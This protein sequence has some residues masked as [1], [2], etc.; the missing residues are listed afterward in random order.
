MGVNLGPL[1]PS[2]YHSLL[3]QPNLGYSI[4]KSGK[5]IAYLSKI[6]TFMVQSWEL[7]MRMERNMNQPYKMI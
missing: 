5:T 7:T 6:M 4:Y 3:S 2:I 1:L